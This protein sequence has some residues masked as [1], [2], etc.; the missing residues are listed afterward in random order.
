MYIRAC[1]SNML[2]GIG[3]LLTTYLKNVRLNTIANLLVTFLILFKRRM[4]EFE[5]FHAMVGEA[6]IGSSSDEAGTIRE[7]MS[8]LPAAYLS[9]FSSQSSHQGG[10]SG[11]INKRSFSGRGGGFW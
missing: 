4:P 8:T 9:L 11:E 3:C 2:E 7:G 10:E 1:A 6:S 5:T